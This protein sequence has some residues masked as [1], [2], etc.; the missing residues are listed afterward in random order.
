MALV[1]AGELQVIGGGAVV[2]EGSSKEQEKFDEADEHG[3]K[4]AHQ[5]DS[6]PSLSPETIDNCDEE[7]KERNGD[8]DSIDKI[9][10]T[11]FG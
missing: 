9:I 7:G 11:Q 2:E 5:G 6:T 10:K 1:K 8:E 3:S 4:D